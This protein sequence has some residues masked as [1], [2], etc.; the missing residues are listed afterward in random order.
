M[1]CYAELVTSNGST[2]KALTYASGAITSANDRVVVETAG[3][4]WAIKIDG[5]YS[6]VYDADGLLIGDF[7]APKAQDY[8]RL[9]FYGYT[10]GVKQRMAS[11]SKAGRLQTVGVYESDTLPS[12]GIVLFNNVSITASGIYSDRVNEVW[13]ITDNAGNY[14]CSNGELIAIRS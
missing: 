12:N 9:D 13:F 4:E 2:S 14:V 8:P 11:L 3:S 5:D 10:S 1:I 6:L 7:D